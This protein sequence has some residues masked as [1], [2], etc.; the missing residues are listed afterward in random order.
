[1]EHATSIVVAEA[2]AS[3]LDHP[4]VCPHG[5]PIPSSRGEVQWPDGVTLSGLGIGQGGRI[6]CIQPTTTDIFAY[7]Q[8]RH[9]QPGQAVRVTDIAPL[10]GPL[11]L[12]INSVEIALGHN[13]AE[14]IM[15][16]PS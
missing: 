2:L 16:Q 11:T 13:L 8:E 5:N 12:E 3:Y 14:L 15:V 9:L 6:L 4:A 10:D 1:M 7:L